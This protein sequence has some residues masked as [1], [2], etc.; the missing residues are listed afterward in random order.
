LRP[1]AITA[2]WAFLRSLRDTQ[3]P[4]FYQEGD[5]TYRVVVSSVQ[6]LKVKVT[7]HNEA[8][9]GTVLVT[10]KTINTPNG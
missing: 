7:E 6:H 5:T 8:W 9:G 3:S 1:S 4:T 2:E 10:M